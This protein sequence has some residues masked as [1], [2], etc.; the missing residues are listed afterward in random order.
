MLLSIRIDL[1]TRLLPIRQNDTIIKIMS[2]DGI[3]NVT[4]AHLPIQKSRNIT[5]SSSSVVMAPVSFPMCEAAV[6]SACAAISGDTHV[7]CPSK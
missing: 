7:R 6:R 5:S 3:I 2:A 4:G 1:G